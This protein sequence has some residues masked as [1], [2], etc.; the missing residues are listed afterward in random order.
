MRPDADDRLLAPYRGVRR[1]VAPADGPWP[2]LLVRTGAGDTSVLVSSADLPAGWRGWDADPSGHV[3]AAF[4][5]VRS[6]AGHSALTP[7]CTERLDDFLRRRRDAGAPVGAGEAVTIGVSIVRGLT[8]LEADPGREAHTGDWWLTDARRP[9]FA[10]GASG[11]ESRA[12]SVGIVDQLAMCAPGPVWD[13]LAELLARDRFTQRDAARVEERLFAFAQ[14]EPLADAPQA[15]RPYAVDAGSGGLRAREVGATRGA[16][17]AREVDVATRQDGSWFDQLSRHV[18][19]DLADLVSK[20]TTGLWRRLRAKREKSRRAPW[21][22]AAAV[23]VVVAGGGLLWPGGEPEPVAADAWAVATAAPEQSG[24]AP[25]TEAARAMQEPAPDIASEVAGL[26]TARTAC[27]GDQS[28]VARYVLDGDAAFLP[29][30]IDLVPSA[31]RIVL[32]D[33]FGAVAVLRAED[34][35]GALPA[36]LLVVQ[37]Q[38][39]SWLLRDVYVAQQP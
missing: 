8:E 7:L 39:E 35:S 23:A 16:R 36:Q 22:V 17:P 13:E 11:G 12:A 34:V 9:V 2:G 25:S 3:L 6:T 31:R 1:V 26:L 14:A 30:V 32:V 15:Q 38:G 27:E 18:D 20:T 21:L 24:P 28:C 37:Q 33:E 4:D 19:A 5:V 29:G 10:V